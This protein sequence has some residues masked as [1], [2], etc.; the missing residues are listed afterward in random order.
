VDFVQAN[1][2]DRALADPL[3]AGLLHR[4]GEF[5]IPTRTAIYFD[6]LVGESRNP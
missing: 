6:R 5:A 2:I 1:G 3:S 4:H